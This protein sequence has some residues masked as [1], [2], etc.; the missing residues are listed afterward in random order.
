M[1]DFP[2]QQLLPPLPEKTDLVTWTIKINGK[3]VPDC[4][5]VTDIVVNRCF[6]RIPFA[7][8]CVLDSAVSE[9]RLEV[10]DQDMFSP[11]NEIEIAV[12]YYSHNT[13]IFNGII[14][15]HAVKIKNRRSPVVEVECKDIA[16]KMT[17]DRKNKQ[18]FDR[19][20]SEIISEILTA[21]EIDHAVEDFE[22]Q[23]Q[24]MIQYYATDWDFINTRAEANAALVLAV[25]GKLHVQRPDFEKTPLFHVEY[26][27]QLYE[28]EAEMDAR[29]QYPAVRTFSWNPT[30][31]TLLA[32]EQNLEPPVTN[33]SRLNDAPGDLPGNPPN[34]DYTNVL[35]VKQFRI[36]HS[37][38]RRAPELQNKA[39]AQALKSRLAS[40]RGRL[41][42]EGRADV[43]PGV[44]IELRNVGLRH[45][46]P[47]FVTAVCHEIGQ[48]AWFTNVQFGLPQEW[49]AKEFP[50]VNG[51]PAVHLLPA[52]CGLQIGVVTGLAGDPDKED[53]IQ[54][55]M[56]LVETEGEGAWA[57]LSCQDAGEN[58]GSFFRP[59]IGDE[60]LL[61]FINDDPR[62]PIVL[63]ML[64]STAKPAPLETTDDNQ[65][66]GWVTRSNIR[67]LLDDD[68]KSLTIQTPG[69][70]K[71]TISDDTQSIEL[72]DQHGNIFKMN[73]DGIEIRSIKDIKL[74]TEHGNLT[75]TGNNI[76]QEANSDWTA[77]SQNGVKL[78][79]QGEAVIQGSFVKIN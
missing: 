47:V 4:F 12:G 76:S 24:T 9:R 7:V 61:G 46:G 28:F 37:G 39:K 17:I 44:T 69:E 41:Q 5:E 18:F 8:F 60:V 3:P 23:H 58:R 15:R 35:N 59:E 70:N 65:Q 26:G 30:E 45:S 29:N 72:K 10:S 43:F 6:N 36:Q 33:S 32:E 38:F 56:P 71:L 14:I 52:V 13:T 49:F 74:Q 75:L 78:K 54:V 22:T 19:S 64:N 16:V 34:T 50:D 53:R 2:S 20:D 48:G 67:M 55:R 42:I 51:G 68:K 21:N 57:R 73:R 25:A 62:D 66:K 40:M 27:D 79:S 11:G 1:F 77:Q 31:Q 63:G